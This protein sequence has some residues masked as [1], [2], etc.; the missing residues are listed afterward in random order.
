MPTVNTIRRTSNLRMATSERVPITR[1]P[2]SLVA[3]DI[4]RSGSIFGAEPLSSSAL[5]MD[6]IRALEEWRTWMSASLAPK[7]QHYYWSVAFRYLADVPKPLAEHTEND[8]AAW[9]EKFPYRSASRRSYFNALLNLFGW[10]ARNGHIERNV[11]RG[12]KVPAP[13]EKVPRAL[14]EEQYEAVRDAAYKRSPVRGYT[15]ELL[16]YTAARINEVLNVRWED[17]TDEGIVLRITKTGNE[18][19]VPWSD[20][21][22]RAVTGLRSFFGEQPYLVPRS[23]QTVWLWVRTAGVDAGVPDVH[24]HLFRSTA[25]TRALVRGARPHAVKQFLGHSKMQ[26]TTRYWAVEDE[27]VKQA[28]NL[29]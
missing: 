23:G 10:A 22:H 27:D 12:I 1:G 21:L 25:A 8:I 6:T 7:S 16:Y 24:P 17:C 2:L 15:V 13:V 26:T 4:P 18:R 5:E 9:L 19:L 29:L 20:G 14:T 11:V 3:D 28:V